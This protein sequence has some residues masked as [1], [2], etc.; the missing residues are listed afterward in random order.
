[1]ITFWLIAGALGAAV[2]FIVLRPLTTGGRKARLS[3]REANISI[4]KDQMRE[5]EADLASGTLGPADFERSK[6]ELEARLLEDVS[7]ADGSTV[8]SH[9]R[10]SALMV[11]I[12]VPLTAVAVYFA[13]GTPQGLDPQQGLPDAAQV[14]AMVGRL[15][16]KLRENP[17]DAEGWKLLGRSY[18]VMGRF[19]DAVGAFAKA[20]ERSPRDAQLLA[21]FADVLAMARGQRL[22]GEPEKL[23]ER[24]L[25]I[26]PKNLKA[27]ALSGT[28]AFERKDYAK[29]AATWGRMLP[30]VPAD[31]EDAR[32]IA[33]NVGEAKKLAAIGSHP[34]VRGT[35]SLAPGLKKDVKPDDTVFVFA[36]AP[37]GP[38]V[39]LA[40]LRA[41][42][43]DLPLKFAL[44]DSLSMAQGM[45]VS[46]HP[47]VVVT[48]RIAKSGKPQAAPGDMQGA[49]KPV[50]NDAAGV[51]VLIDSVVR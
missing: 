22:Q 32:V 4:Y 29:A 11:G 24:A 16:A 50:A 3:R 23:I 8:P 48:A 20:A 30:L 25:E 1:M 7:I 45:T 27:L 43:A 40:V 15:A 47:R 13:T 36:R 51:E 6:L 19:E 12:A 41:R 42:A 18:T 44:D 46:A 14:E 33:E 37:E 10:R 34:G 31:S 26:D 49:S 17:D 5:L 2:L 9:G 38:P 39:P 35:V 21:D 28:V